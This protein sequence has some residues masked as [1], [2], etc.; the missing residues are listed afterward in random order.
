MSRRSM[1]HAVLAAASLLGL[2]VA[3]EAGAQEAFSIDVASLNANG[4]FGAVDCDVDDGARLD[5]ERRARRRNRTMAPVGFG[6]S[7][8]PSGG[9]IDIG[10]TLRSS[11]EQSRG[12]DKI[13]ILFLYNGPEY[14]DLAEKAQVTADGTVYTLS[15]R[16][17]VD[18]ALADWDGPGTVTKCGDTTET[19]TGCFVITD[20]FPAAVKQLDFTAIRGGPLI[21]AL[22]FQWHERVGLLDRLHQSRGPEYR[23]T[24][25][26]HRRY[27]L[28]G[29]PA[30]RTATWPST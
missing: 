5:C 4:C 9:E 6:V 12:I 8:G 18:D 22:L 10:E 24:P 1:V 26:L 2:S 17:D 23:R 20:P 11:F 28:F 21:P 14:G 30:R 13:R 27:G 7:G 16:N 25:G 3:G 29:H 15:V 19:G